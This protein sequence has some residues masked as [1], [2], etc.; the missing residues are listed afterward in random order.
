ML[1]TPRQPGG[2]ALDHPET[3][4]KSALEK[5]V[6]FECRIDQL[7]SDLARSEEECAR[8]KAD[9]AAAAQRELSLKQQLAEAEAR[10]GDAQ[11]ERAETSSRLEASRSQHDQL[12]GRL[13]DA[14]RIRQA[15]QPD[16]G[17][18]LSSFIAE[19]RAEVIAL[20][21]EAAGRKAPS[22]SAPIAV[23]SAEKAAESMAD[24]GRLGVSP[25]D[26]EGLEK[27]ARFQTRSEETLFALSLRELANPDPDS[28][29]RAAQ[30]LKALS[31]K[32]ALP[33]LAASLNGEKSPATVCALLEG[34][35][36]AQ[37][38][39]ALPLVQARLTDPCLEVRLA[40]LESCHK[41][42]DE[43][44]LERALADESPRVRRRAAVLA[45]SE[46]FSPGVLAKAAADKDPSV[47]RVAALALGAAPGVA[48]EAALFSALDDADPSVRRAAAKGLSRALGAEVFAVADLD[49]AR[50][51]REIRRLQALPPASRPV[52]S[53]V[54][55]AAQTAADDAQLA[56]LK[57]EILARV[58]GTLRGQS[59]D[60]LVR[61]LA[62]SAA[63]PRVLE[64]AEAL[65][66]SG[67]LVRRGARYFVP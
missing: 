31:P 39:S 65:Q 17:V 36:A 63:A 56:G 67:A 46:R 15:G 8:L 12:L 9:L 22:A 14:E 35:A 16:E 6:F 38:K 20:R 58:Y 33:A 59:P 53:E 7:G 13:I 49:S 27:A 34:I 44:C 3:L 52:P 62:S 41:L 2:A 30:R 66:R 25:A 26:R 55:A 28:R 1:R 19:L 23:A 5:V 47:R 61:G 64:T 37:E 10:V 43:R 57:K 4:L 32:A 21:A 11:R 51:R 29:T 42:E 24:S 60:E 40:A 54:P 45:S 18:D 48:A 50:R